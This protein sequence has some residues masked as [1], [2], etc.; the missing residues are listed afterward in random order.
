MRTM[1][2]M[3]A[4]A[5]L[6]LALF[7]GTAGVATAQAPSGSGDN[8]GTGCPTNTIIPGVPTPNCASS[9]NPTVLNSGPGTPQNL[10][11]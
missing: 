6:G 5:G 9:G 4:A 8:S 3:T 1:S 2:R 7:L 10:L 11:G